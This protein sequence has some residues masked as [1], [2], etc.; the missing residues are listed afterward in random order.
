[1]DRLDDLREIYGKLTACLP[2]HLIPFFNVF[3]Q[4]PVQ[5]D[6]MQQIIGADR[7]GDDVRI[8]Q[9]GMVF[10]VHFVIRICQYIQKLF[11][12]KSVCPKICHKYIVIILFQKTSHLAHIRIRIG[13][14]KS[15]AMSDAVA[16]CH[17]AHTA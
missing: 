9:G 1:M 17:I 16:Q 12:A 5:T 13:I 8:L 14:R 6:K 3:P 15:I 2:E 4:I 10:A 11:T 7:Q